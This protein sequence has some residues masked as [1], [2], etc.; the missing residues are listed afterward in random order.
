MVSAAFPAFSSSQTL[1]APNG[2]LGNSGNGNV[3]IGTNTPAA[4]LHVSGSNQEIRF[5]YNGSNAYYG[6]LRWDA[7]QLGNNGANRIVA[8]RSQAGGLLDFYVNN[9]NDGADYSLNPDGVLAMRI[10]TSGNVGIGTSTP[11]AKLH[12]N[13]GAT[14]GLVINTANSS[15]WGI[16]MKNLTATGGGLNAYQDNS[17]FVSLY[18]NYPNGANITL[19]QDNGNVGIGVFTPG[20]KLDVR[21]S[22]NAQIAAMETSSGNNNRIIIGA[23][24]TEAY[25]QQLYSTNA[26]PLTFKIND[27]KMR[28]DV[29]G[30]VGIGTTNPTQKLSVNGTVRAKE[31]IVETAGWSD[32]VFADNYALQPLAE[33]EQHIKEYKHLPGLPSAEQVAETGIGVGE[34]QAKLLAKIEELTLH[35]IEQEKR[36]NEQAAQIDLL[37]RENSQL[38]HH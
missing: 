18:N 5:D 36:L 10:A 37:K 31:V 30:N 1:Y 12:V 38:R 3:G 29:S 21:D 4:K 6:S 20:Y 22:V 32:F 28:I 26:R 25:I 27:E 34:M 8:G 13:A 16:I 15:P 14:T 33:V 35:Q 7:L 17:G 19:N 11:G 23:S 24:A 9:I 2:T